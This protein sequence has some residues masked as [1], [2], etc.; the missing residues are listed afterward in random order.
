MILTIKNYLKL[1]FLFLVLLGH[2]VDVV[3][4]KK[5]KKKG[6]T[7]AERVAFTNHFMEGQKQKMIDN[8]EEALVNFNRALKVIP[9]DPTAKYE[10]AR[11]FYDQKRIDDCQS[12]L[13]EAVKEDNNNEW[14]NALLAK[15]YTAQNKLEPALKIYE[16]I[17]SDHPDKK[18]YLFEIANI[19]LYLG[20][21]KEALEVFDRIEESFGLND[22]ILREK[23]NLLDQMGKTK[24][25]IELLEDL[26]SKY[27]SNP[28][29]TGMLA[30]YYSRSGNTSEGRA[31]FEDILKNDPSNGM[32]HLSLHDLLIK[33]GKQDEAIGHLK[34]AIE[35]DDLNIDIKMNILL[36]YYGITESDPS[37]LP[38]AMSMTNSLVTKYPNEPKAHAILGDFLLREGQATEARESFI[39]AVNLAP[40]KTAIWSQ[41]LA[42]DFELGDFENMV[43]HTNE[44]LELFPTNPEYY[45]F[46]GLALNRNEEHEKAIDILNSGKELVFGNN[47]LKTDFFSLLGDSYN[48]LEDYKNSDKSF[49]SALALDA[50]N[51][52]ILNNYSYYLS[53]RGERLEDAEEMIKKALASNLGN[54]S[55]LD[56][57]AWVLF[58]SEKYQEAKIQ[59]EKAIENGGMGSGAVIEHYGDILFK[60]G[61]VDKAMEKW[62]EAK[63]LG[64]TSD[65]LEKKIKERKYYE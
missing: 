26:S 44:C 22:D 51:S 40:D 60:L 63:I 32:A 65:S 30:E 54:P 57:Y 37:L 39:K 28:F 50:G 14:Y 31:K 23:L 6:V 49:N 53:L 20:K 36:T 16:K 64:D 59:I 9:N 35:S 55:Y 52:L 19:N 11:I 61:E 4:Q 58:Q 47:Q 43:K 7:E 62:E 18:D 12:I 41:V 29:Y 3:A 8:P 17:L 5:G 56:T 15:T 38:A 48:E 27:P 25:A 24:D 34:E 33:E 42:L 2:T 46:N 21:N 13:L 10:I 45:Y 1:A